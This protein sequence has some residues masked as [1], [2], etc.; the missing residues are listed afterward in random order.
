MMN[1]S[2]PDARTFPS[3]SMRTVLRNCFFLFKIKIN[4]INFHIH[5]VRR[6]VSLFFKVYPIFIQYSVKARHDIFRSD[7]N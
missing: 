2:S 6:S 5:T 7:F 1:I 3:I 4:I